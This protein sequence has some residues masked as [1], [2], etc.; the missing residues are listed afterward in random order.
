M[1]FYMK[2]KKSVWDSLPFQA[3]VL[4]VIIA[5]LATGALLY[6]NSNNLAGE[7]AQQIT[8]D[9]N[10]RQS[11]AEPSPSGTDNL[12]DNLLAQPDAQYD[13]LSQRTYFQDGLLDNRNLLSQPGSQIS[14]PKSFGYIIEYTDEPV[15]AYKTRLEKSQN[16][17]GRASAAAESAKTYANALEAKTKTY[18]S[19]IQSIVKKSPKKTFT[20]TFSGSYMDITAQEANEVKKLSFV[21]N[22]YPNYEVKAV[23]M[24]SVPLIGADKVWQLDADGNNCAQTGKECLTG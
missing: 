4:I 20:K 13:P 2:N 11:V 6:Q 16:I 22:V 14:I 21:K 5:A 8:L 3:V 12:V 18:D 9:R 10:S 7:A 19:Q 17:A 1:Y 24:D 23:L 15:I